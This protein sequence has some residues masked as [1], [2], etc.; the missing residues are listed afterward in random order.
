MQALRIAFQDVADLLLEQGE[1]ELRLRL[2]FESFSRLPFGCA[3]ARSRD[4]P[5]KLTGTSIPIPFGHHFNIVKTPYQS[6]TG[7]L[8]II[9]QFPSI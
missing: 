6:F 9:Y 7:S 5:Y 8:F 2:K 1:V 3:I 4:L